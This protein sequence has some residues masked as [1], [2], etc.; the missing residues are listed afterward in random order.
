MAIAVAG[1]FSSS[2]A[3]LVGSILLLLGHGF[4][5]AG[6]FF[7]VGAVY[8]RIGTRNIKYY[9]G[10]SITMRVFSVLFVL[11]SFANISVRGMF[12]FIAEFLIF[13]GVMSFSMVSSVFLSLVIILGASYTVWLVNRILFGV[14]SILTLKTTDLSFRE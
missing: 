8:S 9:G 2:T 13:L 1:L 14:T 3:G 12:S 5:S 4:I 11:F 6:L 10:F 7:L